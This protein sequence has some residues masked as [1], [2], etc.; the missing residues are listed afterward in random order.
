MKLNY[1]NYIYQFK[2][3]IY[4]RKPRVLIVNIAYPTLINRI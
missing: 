3:K 4:P 2:V 1:Y